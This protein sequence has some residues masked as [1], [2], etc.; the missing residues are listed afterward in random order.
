[1]P[2]CHQCE[3]LT[4]LK[5]KSHSHYMSGCSYTLKPSSSF[6]EKLYYLLTS[7]TTVMFR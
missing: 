4:T 5:S 6:P 2:S 1:M 7:L 3:Q